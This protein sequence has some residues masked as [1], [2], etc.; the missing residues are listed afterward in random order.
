MFSLEMSVEVLPMLQNTFLQKS[1]KHLIRLGPLEEKNCDIPYIDIS[2]FG[3][4]VSPISHKGEP[5]RR[6][7]TDTSSTHHWRQQKM[8]V[9]QNSLKQAQNSHVYESQGF[10][11]RYT[12]NDRFRSWNN[13]TDRNSPIY[14][15]RV[16]Q[17][18]ETRFFSKLSESHLLS[19]TLHIF[20]CTR[21]SVEILECQLKQGG[22]KSWSSSQVVVRCLKAL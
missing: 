5:W 2:F 16:F 7:I 12:V 15:P 4:G 20:G 6:I 19:K 14:G 9:G 22:K 3:A 18:C 13:E 17:K 1:S 10:Q 11:D 8:L 21:G